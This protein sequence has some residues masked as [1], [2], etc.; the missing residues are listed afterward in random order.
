MIAVLGAGITGLVAAYRLKQAGVPFHLFEASEKI[1]GNMLSEHHG[2]YLLDK[3]P[4]S[5][6]MTDDLYAL[7]EELG[8]TSDILY[9]SEAA[10]N[11]YILRNGKYKALP[12]GPLSLLGNNTFSFSAKRKLLLESFV[13][14]SAQENETVDTFF[15]R[16][17]GDEWTDYAVYPFVSGIYAGNPAELLMKAAF[18]DVLKW[19]QEYGS[20]IKGAVKSRKGQEHKGIFSFEEG[21][22]FLCKKLAE[23]FED[24]IQLG[25]PVSAI[26][27][28]QDGFR[29]DTEKGPFEVNQVI[30]TVPAYVLADLVVGYHEEFS[31]K[32]V[33]INYP[34]VSLVH[35]AF[36]KKDVAHPLDG[37]GALHPPKEGSDILGTIF[38]STVFPNRCPEDEALLC[39][40]VGGSIQ[41]DKGKWDLDIIEKAVLDSH[42]ELLGV[43][44]PVFKYVT[45]W[46]LSIPQYDQ[47][48]LGAQEIAGQLASEGFHAGGNWMG[49]ISVPNSIKQGEKVARACIELSAELESKEQ[50]IIST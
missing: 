21:S 26:R 17:L 25:N 44:E 23:S 27:K 4:N 31:R 11:R 42:K 37:F 8:L 19:E 33:E 39:S 14:S 16:R 45:R 48:I 46:P 20:I 12:S 49:G 32:L 36:K 29:I 41:P 30:S 10:K 28:V 2:P 22:A 40:F 38:S 3:G 18:P 50:T 35:M 47:Y 13:K 15:R 34:P 9:A 7:L 6:R 43:R 24:H 5:L 1:G